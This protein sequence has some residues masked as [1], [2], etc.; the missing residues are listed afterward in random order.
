GRSCANF[1]LIPPIV[2]R[3]LELPFFVDV[4]SPDAGIHQH[5]VEHDALP[6]GHHQMLGKER[7]C[8]FAL[9]ASWLSELGDASFDGRANGNH[10]LPV[11]HNRFRNFSLKRITYLA[12][13]G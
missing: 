5:G 9:D 1:D 7:N 10:S 11:H 6:V 12:A 4:S 3:T 13:E 8:R 2:P